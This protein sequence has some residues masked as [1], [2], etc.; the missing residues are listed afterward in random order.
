MGGIREAFRRL[1]QSGPTR[2]VALEAAE[3]ELALSSPDVKEMTDFI[4]A[5][6]RGV[7]PPRTVSPQVDNDEV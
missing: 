2:L 5:A 3:R 7:C 6:E 1:F 4:R